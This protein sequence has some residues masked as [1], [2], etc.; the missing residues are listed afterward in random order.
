MHNTVHFILQGKGGIG[1]SF[2]AVMLAQYFKNHTDTLRCLDT[3]QVNTT[4]AH[5]K[6][7]AVRHIPVMTASRTIDAKRFDALIE[8]LISEEGTFVVDNGAN[9]FSP[10]LAYMIENDV[11]AFL[12]ENGKT[13]YIHTVVGGGDALSD[14]ANGFDSIAAGTDKTQLVLW[15][16]EHFGEMQTAQ[17]KEFR[18]T[19]VFLKHEDRLLGVLTLQ[20]RNHQTY[21]EDV[22]KMNTR[23]MTVDEVMAS[24]DFF[25][26]EK[27]RIKNV[28]NDIFAQLDTIPF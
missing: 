17:G 27:Q 28:A 20:A 23:R 22:K 21:C 1:K 19:K 7:L 2:I 4:F 15:L 18:D 26:M 12:L 16:N 14:T 5:Y 24:Q 9:T 13:V 6:A 10:L 3:D 8:I 25:L 11:I